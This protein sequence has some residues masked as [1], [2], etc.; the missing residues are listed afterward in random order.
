MRPMNYG[1][2]GS[3]R[4]S[5][6]PKAPAAAAPPVQ[7]VQPPPAEPHLFARPDI[8]SWAEFHA[9]IDPYLD[10]EHLFRGVTNAAHPLI[11]AVGR[12]GET[13]MYSRKLEEE[14][15][16]EFKREAVPYLKHLIGEDDDWTWLAL[17]QHHGVPT[18]LL[19]WS[20]SPYV[21]LF[22]AVWGDRAD[23]AK[24]AGVYVIRRPDRVIK[25]D[26]SP[27]NVRKGG[28][29]FPR[30]ITA[31]ITAQ[32]GLFTVQRYPDQPYSGTDVT[33]L[34]IA[35]E[36]KPEIRKKLDAIGV[37]DASIFADLE[38]LC[39]RLKA[40]RTRP[41]ARLTP[42]DAALPQEYQRGPYVPSD[43][44][45]NQWGGRPDR[46]GFVLSATVAESPSSKN[47][48]E[49]RLEVRGKGKLTDPVEFHLHDTFPKPVRTVR[50]DKDGIV[51]EKVWSYGAFTVG[52][53]VKDTRLELDLAKLAGVPVKFATR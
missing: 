28:F 35:A 39:R 41:I 12:N 38:G 29:F 48:F 18:R 24:D 6:A 8:S 47:W 42:V 13:W 19:D 7:E 10:G 49:V 33:Q 51:R 44:Q 9:G 36:A 15:L 46:N 2:R 43:P 40:S 16:E 3:K 50:P 23:E 4:K 22:F 26:S 17:A 11:P 20:E 25:F 27:F 5:P 14:L 30:H 21:A 31:R 45:K 53:K 52:A 34:I 32:S 1:Q 37:H